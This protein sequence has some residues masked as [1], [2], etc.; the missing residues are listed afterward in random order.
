MGSVHG[1]PA[2]DSPEGFAMNRSPCKGKGITL[3]KR[4]G[5]V[6]RV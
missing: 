2:A 3:S 5:A 6:F 1:E 4:E